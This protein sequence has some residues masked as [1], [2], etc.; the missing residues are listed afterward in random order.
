MSKNAPAPAPIPDPKSW[1]DRRK[2][3]RKPTFLRAV[4][5]D[6]NGQNP[7]DCT[8]LD[9]SAGGAQVSAAASY[10]TGAQV[11]LLDVGNQVA[12]IAK[13]A[14]SKD[15]RSGLSFGDKHAIGMGLAPSHSFLWR[16]LLE[17]KL[18]DIERDIGKGAP[19]SLAFMIADL[20]EVQLHFMAQRATG[21]ARFEQALR[22]ASELLNAKK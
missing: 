19:V 11:C 4:V 7:Q 2:F 15:G 13:V 1:E 9:I 20:S 17:A 18:R 22:R 10:A 3:V 12:Y 14:W 8:V 6:A 5:A 16:L 21:D